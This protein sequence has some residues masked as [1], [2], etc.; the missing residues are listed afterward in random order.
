MKIELYDDFTGFT[1]TES[2]DSQTIEKAIQSLWSDWKDF[3]Y[4]LTI[5]ELEDD[6]EL[7]FDTEEKAINEWFNFKVDERKQ[8]L[9]FNLKSDKKIPQKVLTRFSNHVN[10]IVQ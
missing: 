2:V 9:H 5:N 10:M 3:M 6:W 4:D 7:Y 8:W 1:Y